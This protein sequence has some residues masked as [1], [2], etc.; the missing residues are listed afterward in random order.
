MPYGSKTNRGG[1]KAGPVSTGVEGLTP[2]GTGGT[3][4]IESGQPSNTG[5]TSMR[6]GIQTP[7]EFRDPAGA[8]SK[9]PKGES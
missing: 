4:A 5:E 1:G 7:N 9:F 6:G 2:G 3:K 8:Y